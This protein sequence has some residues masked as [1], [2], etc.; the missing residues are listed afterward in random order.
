M[1]LWLYMLMLAAQFG[2]WVLL[3]ASPV[4][5]SETL[6]S[7]A[8]VSRILLAMLF[9]WGVAFHDLDFDAI[10]SGE[11]DQKQVRKELK[12]IGR[13]ARAQITKDYVAWPII[14]GLVMTAIEAGVI[15]ARSRDETRAQGLGA[16]MSWRWTPSSHTP[17]A[18]RCGRRRRE[19]TNRW[20]ARR[21]LTSAAWTPSSRS[22]RIVKSPFASRALDCAW[23]RPWARAPIT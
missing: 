23:P 10:R 11:K 8:F 15:A 20:R 7:G 1:I 22:T 18:S 14:S 17:I 5:R 13:K 21:S 12:G 9:E 6:P 2:L 3:L 16:S 19:R 4:V